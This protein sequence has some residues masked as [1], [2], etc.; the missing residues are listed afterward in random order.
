MSNLRR[1]VVVL[2]QARWA[3]TSPVCACC[4]VWF[5]FSLQS[6]GILRALKSFSL[7][8]KLN[9][10]AFECRAVSGAAVEGCNVGGG[11]PG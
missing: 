2:L 5:S 11:A 7:N 6:H 3:K 9:D 1:L 8:I 4:S 10:I